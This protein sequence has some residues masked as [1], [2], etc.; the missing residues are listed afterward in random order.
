MKQTK[1]Q[2]LA[3][4]GLCSSLVINAFSDVTAVAETITIE[5]SPTVASS[6]KEATS[7]SSATPASTESSQETTETSRE[8]V[9]QETEKPEV[10]EKI[11]D[12]KE[13]TVISDY[14][15]KGAKTIPEINKI[16]PKATYNFPK[17]NY[18]FGFVDEAGNL[19]NPA[20]FSI[21][22]DYARGDRTTVPVKWTVISA[23]EK[24]TDS[25]DNLKNMVVPAVSLA[26][27]AGG[28]IY[29]VPSNFRL[30]I[31]KYY[32]S[33]S[34]YNSDGKINPKYPVPI[35]KQYDSGVIN[36]WI[37]EFHA[38]NLT[39]DEAGYYKMY[40][41]SVDGHGYPLLMQRYVTPPGKISHNVYTY[42]SGPV[43]YHLINRKVTENFVDD[44]GTKITPPTGFTQ[45]K[46]TVIDSDPY[47][48][49][50]SGTL[51]ET[52][53]ASN[54]KTYKFKGWYKGKTKPNTLTATKAP[55]YA[56][57]YDDN[58]DLNVVYEEIEAFDF[59]ALTYQFGFV[60]EDGKLA[61][62]ADINITYDYK[63]SAYRGTG[64]G[65]DDT[66]SFG[67]IATNQSATT[68]GNLKNVTMPATSIARPTETGYNGDAYANF[69]IKL[70]RYY[71]SLNLYDKTG[72]INPSYPLPAYTRKYSVR[73]DDQI[74]PEA[75]VI[76]FLR[77][78]QKPDQS[79]A[80]YES[81]SV[82]DP[83]VK[84]PEFLQ[85]VIYS[86]D[87]VS[88]Y[89]NYT[90]FSSPVYYHLT[91]RKVTENFVDANGTKITP[92]TGF[93]QGKQT[94]INSDPYTFK[95]SGTLPDTYTT[96]GKTYKFKG[97][98]KGKTKPN[99]LTTTKAPSY[100]VT[101]DDN[102]DL[103]VV[104][105]EETVTTLYPSMNVNFVDEKGVGFTPTLTF[106]GKYRVRRTSDLLDIDLYDV[107]SKSK[108]N[109]QYTIS[110]NYGMMP[111][112]PEL[113]KIYG[114]NIAVNGRNQLHF[115]FNQFSITNQLKYVDSIALDTT[116]T[117]YKV[118]R[119]DY[120]PNASTIFDV[121][122][123]PII[124]D[125]N[126][127]GLD[128]FTSTNGYFVQDASTLL[129]MDISSYMNSI[130]MF[131]FNTTNT[132]NSMAVYTVTRKQVTENFVNT[133][134]AKITPP[135]GFT[136]GNQIPMTS[137]T[138]K[139][140]AAKALPATY[141][142]GGKTYTFQGWYK[143]KTKP[144]T[145]TTSTTPTYNTTFDGNDDMTAM[146]KEEVPKASVA[147]TRTTAETVTSGG[148][149]TWRATITNT[150]QA[151]LTTATIK[152]ST[153]WT[154][155]LAAPTAMIVTPAGGTAKTVPVTATTWTNGVSL[156]TD[157]PAGKSATVQF[158]TKATGT[159]G[160]V[161]RAGITTS[162]NYSGVSA[163]A[164]VRVKDNDQ[165]IVTPT[166]EGFISVPTFNF[167]QV[168]VA[169]STQQHSLKKAADYYGNG[170]RNPYLRIKKTQPNWS[171]TAQLSQPKSATDSLP[172]ATRLL[173]GAAPV[174]SFSNYNQ[175]TE[176]K[177]AVGTTSAISLNAN[178][179]ATRIIANQQFTGSNIYQLDFTF[180][181]VKLEVPANQGV[182]GQQYQAAITWNL[183]TGP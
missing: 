159:A 170:T 67:T 5:S 13:K 133:S 76:A 172:T 160:Q 125:A 3:T 110:A 38:L 90:T 71:Q 35:V 70:P 146:Y 97:W 99:T 23:N 108:G 65:A 109:G 112:S 10:V 51:P 127:G 178:N 49:K 31:P 148:N 120:T 8:E 78:T 93:T 2:R 77:L 105:E 162:G 61:N 33:I 180:N 147:L 44:N 111:L 72:K 62:P 74:L 100:A 30:T 128:K 115:R 106:G 28:A 144:N 18:Q 121:N 89:A 46:Q 26:Q 137:N 80:P 182:K 138:F 179:T 175:P 25:A 132:I 36:N 66:V 173:L 82:V 107:T 94:V 129:Y 24:A 9:T 52:Y 59:P 143:G 140:T 158:T 7:A 155:G 4:I 177:N 87:M 15:N 17:V 1:W 39:K 152:K 22:F 157:I 53:K 84:Y 60:G 69:S 113:L 161:L 169:G 20:P 56:V 55:S 68:V 29:S 81:Y 149:V 135:T 95:Q 64:G 48:F 42:F 151:P 154:T 98:Y 21:L 164:T 131:G 156:G 16:S 116:K 92:P 102:D 58:D 83:S 150:S 63:T 14:L 183:V 88:G 119:Y 126:V 139:Y 165:A 12:D 11:S 6:A 153:A 141:T 32:S 43:Y 27:P 96:G 86:T 50:Q 79:Y 114:N 145:L 103:N 166:A 167:G 85:R 124:E 47:T 168:G 117:T 19:M 41:T 181:N 57:T 136:Q 45:G 118:T 130:R 122:Q 171:L 101:Y 123:P 37:D 40:D 34:I 73:Y 176:L 134:G 75:S 142:A 104:Y 174:S 91:N 163:S 54:G